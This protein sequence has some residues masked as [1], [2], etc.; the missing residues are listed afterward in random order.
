MN[1]T[2]LMLA[3][4][5]F[6]GAIYFGGCWCVHRGQADETYSWTRTSGVVETMTMS[7]YSGRRSTTYTPHVSYNFKV[8]GKTYHGDTISFPSPSFNNEPDSKAFQQ[9][10]PEGG[11]TS[12]YYDPKNPEK[13]CLT[14]GEGKALDREAWAC[15]GMMALSAILP[16]LPARSGY[17]YGMGYNQNFYA[18]PSRYI[19][20]SR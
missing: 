1:N 4:I 12:V 7:T 9:T 3:L 17:G 16:F 14:P 18:G 5:A 13:S 8:E 11:L 19:T 6:V 2:N 20:P 15:V 10:Y